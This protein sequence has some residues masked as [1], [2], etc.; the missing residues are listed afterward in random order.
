MRGD[1]DIRPNNFS[2]NFNSIRKNKYG[3]I[4][5]A[6]STIK[7]DVLVPDIGNVKD[8]IDIIPDPL[9]WD[10]LNIL[11]RFSDIAKLRLAKRLSTRLKRVNK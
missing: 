2:I 11:E 10:V 5:P 9:F 7:K 1:V 4:N 8:I 3:N 6:K